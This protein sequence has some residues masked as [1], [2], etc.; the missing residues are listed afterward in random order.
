[1]R[2]ANVPQMADTAEVFAALSRRPGVV[3]SA[4]VPNVIGARRAVAA[5]VDAVQVF[6]SA[7]ESHNRSNV[8]MSIEQSL[9]QAA[10][11]AAVAV[12]PGCGSRQW[13]RWPSVARSR[14]MCRLIA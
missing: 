7:S 4:I 2:P 12:R 5:R 11:I 3:Y 6:L 1:M 8:N 9:T 14:G 13:C 10:D